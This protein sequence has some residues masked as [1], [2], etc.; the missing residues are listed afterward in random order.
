MDLVWQPLAR[1]EGGYSIFVH[2]VGESGVPVGQQDRRQDGA[3]VE[4]GVEEGQA[5]RG[6]LAADEGRVGDYPTVG[7]VRQRDQQRIG[8]GRYRETV[9]E[10]LVR[11]ALDAN[12]CYSGLAA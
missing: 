4:P 7:I 9:G 11:H 10:D 12:A 8:K 3:H 6:S 1:L 5:Q 2:L